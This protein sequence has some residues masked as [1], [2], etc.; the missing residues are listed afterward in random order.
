MSVDSFDQN[1][2]AYNCRGDGGP[3]VDRDLGPIVTDPH[4]TEPFDPTD[5]SLDDPTDAAEMTSV[6]CVALPNVRFNAQPAQYLSRG[7]AIEAG[8]GVKLVGVRT[9]SP[10]LPANHRNRDHRGKDF[11]LVASVARYG[12]KHQRRTLTIH[13]QREFRPLFPAIHGTRARLLTTAERAHLG[14]VDD[15]RLQVQLLFMVQHC[16]EQRV[17]SAPDPGLLPELHSGARCFTATT[18]FSRHIL[19]TAA[20]DQHKPNHLQHGPVRDRRSPTHW[21]YFLLR[22]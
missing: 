9:R 10:R 2:E 21:T 6:R 14:R 12:P 1:A 18:Q 3:S 19:P 20:S 15:L 4:S 8:V 11:Q 13:H 17:D 22:G 16:Q 7:V 5:C